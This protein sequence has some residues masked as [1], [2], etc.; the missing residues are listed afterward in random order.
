MQ[1]K[2]LGLVDATL[3]ASVAMLGIRWLPVAAASG[4]SSLPLWVLAFFTFYVPLSVATAE[5]TSRFP[6]EGSIYVWLRDTYGPLAGFLCGWFYWISLFPFFASTVYFLAGLVIG[7]MGGDAHDTGL[8]LAVSLGITLF[9][10]AFQLFGLRIGK[11]M[12]NFGAGGSWAVFALLAVAAI[13][14]A[15]GGGSATDFA[16]GSYLPSGN[17]D[18]AI[19]WGTLVFALCGSETIAFLRNDIQGGM[20]TAVRVLAAVGIILVVVYALGTAAMLVV[21]PKA[22]LTRLSGLPDAIHAAFGRVGLPGLSNLAIALFALSMLGGFTA[23]F[24]IGTKLPMEAGIDHFLPPVFA[25]KNEK[26]GVPTASV[27][28]QGG[29]I[30]LM[31]VLS[32][33]GEGAAAA[34]DFLVSMSVLGVTIPYLL[35]FIAYLSRRR[36]PQSAEAW[37]PPGGARMG[38]FLGVVGLVSTAVATACTMVPNPADAHPLTTFLKI[39]LATV[40]AGVIGVVLYWLGHRRQVR[41]AA[42]AT[43]A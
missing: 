15:S 17:F 19:L 25:K 23:W 4:V 33:A 34:Y 9:A 24:G 1:T 8:Y 30:L 38:L 40:A 20:K 14:L 32:Q 3:Y 18:T 12:T 13:L 42:E 29:L 2:Q 5:L 36:W 21:L 31:V 27:L 37:I 16:S 39:A 10:S 28:L 35:V 41:A 11:W 22:E 6:G 43:A 7:L 26:T